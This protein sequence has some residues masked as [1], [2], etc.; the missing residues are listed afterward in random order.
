MEAI[1]QAGSLVS[2]TLQGDEEF[3]R[4]APLLRYIV[5]PEDFGKGCQ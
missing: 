2:F 5:G 3:G 4:K 1:V